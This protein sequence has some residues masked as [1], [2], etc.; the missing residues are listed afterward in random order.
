MR[1][2]APHTARSYAIREERDFDRDVTLFDKTPRDIGAQGGHV[3]LLDG[4]AAWKEMSKMRTYRS[5]L[6]WEDAGAF[7]M[8]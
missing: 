3:G 7:G 2:L 6:L 4:S 5:S 8:W 1:I